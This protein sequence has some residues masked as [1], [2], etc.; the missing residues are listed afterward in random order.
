MNISSDKVFLSCDTEQIFLERNG[1][2]EVL[3]EKL[4]LLWKTYHF[5]KVYVVNWPWWFTNLRVGS[6]ALNLLNSFAEHQISFYS[7]SKIDLYKF[8]YFEEKSLPQY[9]IIYIGQ[10]RNVWIWNFDENQLVCQT[11]F[12]QIS[13]V[14]NQKHIRDYQIFFDVV[15]DSWYYDQ[16]FSGYKHLSSDEFFSLMQHYCQNTTI[17]DSKEIHANYMMDPLITPSKKKFIL[18]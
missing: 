3:W 8:G 7:F 17:L 4:V 10:K 2:E 18:S 9:W 16:E 13:T 15:Y 6:I 14:L 1:I 5:T 11:T 12:D